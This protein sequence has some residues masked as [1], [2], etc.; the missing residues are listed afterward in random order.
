MDDRLRPDEQAVDQLRLGIK[1][2]I[3][4]RRRSVRGAMPHAAR[5]ARS[6]T[7]TKHVLALPEWQSARTVMA[8]VSM[9]TEVQTASLIEAARGA[10]KRVAVPRMTPTFDELEVREWRAEEELEE[11]G[12][13]F[14]QPPSCAPVVV[15]HEVDLVIVPALAADARGHRIGY[16]KGFYD[17]LLPRLTR[18]TR[19]GVL[20]EHELV[21]EVP[22]RP[23]DERLHVVVTD[24]GVLRIDG[25]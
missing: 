13:M 23:G 20:F 8:F 1:A 9:R 4:K 5:V 15:E 17:R 3:R 10:Q 18:A 16:G 19:V 21:A 22:D 12:M 7:I 2:E 14:L 11:S 24:A 25:A 6:E